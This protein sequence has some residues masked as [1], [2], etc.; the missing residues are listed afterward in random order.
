M[1]EMNEKLKEE[2][3]RMMVKEKQE[4]LQKQKEETD[5]RRLL[6]AKR[7]QEERKRQEKEKNK[8]IYI[9]T[10]MPLLPTFDCYDSDIEE[11]EKETTH[12]Q[13]PA[14]EKST[15]SVLI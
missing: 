6:A 15:S 8:P 7:A 1:L 13:P 14:W 12:V 2:R 10:A 3:A 5:Q 9:T 4:R 11:E